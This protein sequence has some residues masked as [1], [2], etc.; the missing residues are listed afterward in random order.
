MDK[1]PHI[2]WGRSSLTNEKIQ[3]L[4]MNGMEEIYVMDHNQSQKVMEENEVVYLSR[5]GVSSLFK[6][7]PE[8][9]YHLFLYIPPR[10][11]RKK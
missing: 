8:T 6:Y 2:I 3:L 10:P 11:E 7:A 1:T 5:E 9:V 4:K